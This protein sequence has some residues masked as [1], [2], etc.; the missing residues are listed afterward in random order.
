MTASFYVSYYLYSFYVC[1]ALST[2]FSSRSR[3]SDDLLVSWKA[4]WP[5]ACRTA[6]MNCII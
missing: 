1:L 3:P 2:M 5:G 6:G 4:N